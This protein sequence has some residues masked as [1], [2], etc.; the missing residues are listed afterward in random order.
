MSDL[1]RREDAIVIIDAW[2]DFIKLN[3]DILI[4]SIKAIPTAKPKAGKWL[5]YKDEHQ[6]SLCKEV[7]IGDWHNDDD[8][9]EY[10]P[11]CGAK[12]G[13]SE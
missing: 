1:I 9:F 8:W 4:E 7:V 13:R 6:C 10:C 11:N 12:M 3:L 2:F 5:D